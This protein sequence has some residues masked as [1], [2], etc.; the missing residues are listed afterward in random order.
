MFKTLLLTFAFFSSLSAESDSIK[1]FRIY[2]SA[3]TQTEPIA[4][5]DPK[6]PNILFVSGVT[7]NTNNGF[8]SEGV[9]FTTDAGE[10][11]FGSD[12]CKGA[13][14]GNHGGDPGVA[15]DTNGTF[16]LTHIGSVFPGV[17]S[18]Y[19][20]N[21]G[22]SWSNAYTIT[23]VQPEDKGTTTSDHSP[24]SPYYGR[25]YTA[26][27]NFVN[28]FPVLVSYTTNGGVNWS[29]PVT[30]NSPPPANS[31]GGFIKTGR[32]G[33]VF[34][35]WAGLGTSF[36]FPE[37][38]VGFGKSTDGGATWSVSQNIFDVAGIK[39]TLAEKNNIRVN[40]L[41]V[42]GV[43]KSGGERDGWIYILTTQKN[44]PPAGSDPDIILHRSTDGGI[45]WSQ[46]I[47]VNQDPLNNGKIQ[48]FPYIDV[49]KFGAVNII[50]YDDRN[51]SSDSAQ[52]FFAR[53]TDGGNSWSEK[54][55]SGHTFKPKPIVGGSSTY[56]GD[57]ISI[58][59]NNTHIFA[60]WMDDYSG[61]Y[62]IWCAK[63]PFST[64]TE[65]KEFDPKPEKFSI[66]EFYPQPFNSYS[67]VKIYSPVEG[68]ITI[69]LYDA[70]GNCIGELHSGIIQ[71]GASSVQLNTNKFNLPSG[72]YY[73]R[74][75][76][77]GRSEM[78][79]L[80]YLK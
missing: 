51:T 13:F 47:R 5:I 71:Q 75:S 40:G 12:T 27:V 57:H 29:S 50:F 32:A 72:I 23:S 7:I 79:K 78:K 17:Y 73:C 25:I 34:V 38:F 58:T 69:T 42:I 56:Q 20:T 64:I 59:S 6:N 35:T 67:N 30:L 43:D 19:S 80:M 8:K 55:I 70:I 4:V 31:S 41:P 63:I 77:N 66:S 22:S 39:G 11:W 14:I 60:F 74:I 54:L 68:Y 48:Y 3:V 2:P 53:S 21:F 24:S 46:G 28:P 76:M 26:W 37:D 36:P 15:V 52:L 1:V 9:Y 62:Q 65:V 10:T 49:D 61:I 33:E 18:H 44:L 16:V 45:T